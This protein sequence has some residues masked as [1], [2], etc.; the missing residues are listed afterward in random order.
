MIPSV[1]REPKAAN[2]QARV[3]EVQGLSLQKTVARWFDPSQVFRGEAD[4]FVGRLLINCAGTPART[5]LIYVKS[6]TNIAA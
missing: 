6:D 4:E 3:G 2:A 5:R 1:L